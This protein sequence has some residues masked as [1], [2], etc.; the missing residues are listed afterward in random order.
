MEVLRASAVSVALLLTLTSTARNVY[1][2][3]LCTLH[4]FARGRNRGAL[5]RMVVPSSIASI[6]T[7]GVPP[8]G[9]IGVEDLAT[10]S[11]VSVS[12]SSYCTRART[13]VSLRTSAVGTIVTLRP[14]AGMVDACDSAK[15]PS[16]TKRSEVGVWV[17]K[18]LRTSPP[19][20]YL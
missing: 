16:G 19:P 4:S 2:V 5:R 9:V 8:T 17:M 6:C 20:S 3:G 7:A 1:R 15:S 11:S 10:V 12:I 13:A 18:T 14:D